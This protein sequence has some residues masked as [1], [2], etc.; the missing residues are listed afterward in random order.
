MFGSMLLETGRG[1]W[2]PLAS[3]LPAC[4][5]AVWRHGLFTSPSPST[6][7]AE[8]QEKTN[9]SSLKLQPRSRAGQTSVALEW[10]EINRSPAAQ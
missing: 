8:L 5:G 4:E 7:E 1:T 6:K 9:P 10:T 3:H 2:E